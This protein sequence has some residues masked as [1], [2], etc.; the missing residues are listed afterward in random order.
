MISASKLYLSLLFFLLKK[1]FLII[2]TNNAIPMMA[3]PNIIAKPAP[4]IPKITP[5]IANISTIMQ[6]VNK[7]SSR[8]AEIVL[9]SKSLSYDGI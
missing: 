1:I 4:Q 5:A 6:K 2:N 3:S 9:C 7:N 8:G